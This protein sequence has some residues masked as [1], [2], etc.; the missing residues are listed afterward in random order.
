MW[1]AI[2]GVVKVV[3][4]NEKMGLL[5]IFHMWPMIHGLVKAIIMKLR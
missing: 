5:S 2:D 1:P 3:I 4:M